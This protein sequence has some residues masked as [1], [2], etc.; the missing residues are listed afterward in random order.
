MRVVTAEGL[1]WE[2]DQN[3]STAVIHSE[4]LG[5][6]ELRIEMVEVRPGDFVPPHRHARRREFFS[7]AY[8]AGAQMQIGERIFRPIAGQVFEREAGE[9]LAITNDTKHPLRLMI[10]RIGYDPNDIEWLNPVESEG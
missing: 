8:S 6:Q 5:D 3:P 9:V 2:S 1:D 4:K 10:T 7:V